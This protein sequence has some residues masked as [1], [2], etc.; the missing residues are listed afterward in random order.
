MKHEQEKI[1]APLDREAIKEELSKDKF[2]R[3]TNNA[4]NEIY[5]IDAH[6]SPMVMR[7]VARLREL[8]FRMAGGGTGK[9]LDMDD[10]DTATPPYKQLIVWDPAAHEIVGGYRYLICGEAPLRDNGMPALATAG[11]FHFSDFF[12]KDYLPHTIE[13]GR[14][15]VQPAY[16]P[17]RTNRKS[18]YSLDNLWDGLGALVVDYPEIHYFFGKVTMYTHFNTRA[19]DLILYFLSRF[20]PDPD[21]LVYPINPLPLNTSAKEMEQ[22]FVGENFE[23]NY[24]IL[25]KLV[26]DLNENIPP[27]INSYMNLSPTMRSFGTAINESFG[28]VEETGILITIKDIYDTKKERHVKTYD[29]T[30][31]SF[32]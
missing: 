18:I 5:L 6:N 32:I 20:F 3:K 17:S 8:S 21:K 27:L 2:L 23:D 24:K 25:F 26:R 29:K 15:F 7:E 30:P 14:S 31:Y 9:S 13:L 12:I 28:W 10:Y 11:L 1:I 16:Q 4:K 19:R 22:I